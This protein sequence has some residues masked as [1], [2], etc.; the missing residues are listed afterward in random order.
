M[1]LCAELYVSGIT[2]FM[3]RYVYMIRP[4]MFVPPRKSSS[5]DFVIH[6]TITL[7]RVEI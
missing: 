1:F 2:P 3:Y 4:C 7:E 6:I 5:G